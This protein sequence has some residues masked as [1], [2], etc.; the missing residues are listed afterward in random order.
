MVA[1]QFANRFLGVQPK[2]SEGRQL[3]QK[4]SAKLLCV[5][6]AGIEVPGKLVEITADLA[7]LSQQVG[8]DAQGIFA[9][10]CN[11]DGVLDRFPQQRLTNEGRHADV[12]PFAA[13]FEGNFFFFGHAK[14]DDVGTVVR[15]V[16]VSGRSNL[17]GVLG[18][19]QP[20]ILWAA[21]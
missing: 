18:E 2:G 6:A 14:F 10:A 16:I 1:I 13:E 20:P 4:L 8:E 11:N 21:R 17:F 9:A 3:R 5:P 19:Y 7:A 15:I 12:E